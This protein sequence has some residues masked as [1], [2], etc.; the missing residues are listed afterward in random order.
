MKKLYIVKRLW[1][2]E[3]DFHFTLAPI[4]S[5]AYRQKILAVLEIKVKS[6]DLLPKTFQ[7]AYAAALQDDEFNRKLR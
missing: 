4:L 3:D 1:K 6:I 7:I 2:K 5:G